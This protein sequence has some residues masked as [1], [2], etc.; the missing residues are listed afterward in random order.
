[1]SELRSRKGFCFA[2]AIAITSVGILRVGLFPLDAP[3]PQPLPAGLL[4]KLNSQG[5]RVGSTLAAQARKNVSNAESVVLTHGSSGDPGVLPEGV[6]IMLMPIRTRIAEQLESTVIAR[7]INGKAPE[8]T[9]LLRVNADQFLRFRAKNQREQ[10]ISCIA[11]GQASTSDKLVRR[12]TA[13]PNQSWLDRMR[14]SVG[15]QPL[16]DWNCLFIT[17]SLEPDAA[18]ATTSAESDQLITNVW[19][20]LKPMFTK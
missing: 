6:E 9:R 5:W 20:G 1:M 2:V 8:K 16:T 13:T 19:A 10:A 14:R 17:I 18:A 12:N 3:M 15:L 4:E 7:E 11:G